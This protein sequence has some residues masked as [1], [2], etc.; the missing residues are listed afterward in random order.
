MTP[1]RSL[2]H[3]DQRARLHYYHQSRSTGTPTLAAWEGALRELH[4]RRTL[5]ADVR[6]T[7]SRSKAAKRGWTKR[8][9]F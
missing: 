7:K 1:H 2:S 3:S 9:S 4:F 6:A 5:D 8:R